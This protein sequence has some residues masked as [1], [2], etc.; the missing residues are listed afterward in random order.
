MI[1]FSSNKLRK[2]L[3][4]DSLDSWAKA[5]YIILIMAMHCLSGPFY[6]LIPS[7]EKKELW[8]HT[9]CS[10]FSGAIVILLT[11]LGIR[12]CFLTNKKGDA[13]DFIGRFA[14]LYVPVI[15]Q[16]IPLLLIPYLVIVLIVTPYLPVEKITEEN[17]FLYTDLLFPIGITY[18][19]YAL[20]N[21]P[22]EKLVE[23]IREREG[24]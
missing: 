8:P 2:V 16:L 6:W 11:I 5:K 10:V 15:F 4:N 23:M 7:F 12:K 1:I 17:I 19:F 9:L 3:A 13:K 24:S 14:V 20:L 21:R 18:L 22:F